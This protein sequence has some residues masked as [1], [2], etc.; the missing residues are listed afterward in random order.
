MS[1]SKPIKGPYQLALFFSLR[2]SLRRQSCFRE[3]QPILLLLRAPPGVNSNDYSPVVARIFS[4][5][6][7]A[8]SDKSGFLTISASEKTNAVLN[9]FGSETEGRDRVIIIKDYQAETP[10]KIVLAIDA[11]VILDKI[12][13]LD[14]RATCRALFGIRVSASDA[15][16]ALGSL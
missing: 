11:E 4:Q 1:R 8:Y 10:S 15:E 14:F 6:D 2:R 12:S 16:A 9:N 3:G 7:D 13:P 5:V